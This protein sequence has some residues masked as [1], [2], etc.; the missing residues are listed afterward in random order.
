MSSLREVAAKTF[1]VQTGSIGVTVLLVS[2][3]AL[4][5]APINNGFYVDRAHHV[6]V[7]VVQKKVAT[8]SVVCHG[9][10]YYPVHGVTV[11]LGRFSYTGKAAVAHGQHPPAATKKTLIIAGDFVTSRRVTGTAAVAGC[12]VSYSAKYVGSHP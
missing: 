8:P 4:A 5:A 2:A 7:I 9:T 11:K 10:R 1:S 12:N 3:V 6:S